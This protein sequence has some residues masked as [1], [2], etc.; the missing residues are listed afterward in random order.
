MR[1]AF[2]IVMAIFPAGAD[3][4]KIAA[5]SAALAVILLLIGFSSGGTEDL[6]TQIAKQ[7]EV[8]EQADLEATAA[9]Q[10]FREVCPKNDDGS[11]PACLEH[12]FVKLEFTQEQITCGYE[13]EAYLELLR[14]RN[15]AHP[16]AT[17]PDY[18]EGLAF[19]RKTSAPIT[20]AKHM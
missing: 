10:K 11:S 18:V 12:G 1:L 16:E 8:V 4:R 7:L 17:T 2:S 20:C 3:M 15:E 14:E 9:G 13:L 19:N 5:G 6:S